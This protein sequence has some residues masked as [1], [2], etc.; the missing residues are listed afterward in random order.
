MQSIDFA[1]AVLLV[2]SLL[3]LAGIFSS[4]IASRLGTPLLLV[5]MA[6]GMLAGEDGPGGIRFSDF[7][8]AYLIGS[9]ALAVI[10]FDGGLRTKLS[11]FRGVLAPSLVL[12]TLGVIITAVITGAIAACLLGIGWVEGFLIGAIV[13]STD[14]AAVFF[15]LGV[16][17]LRLQRR[18]QMTLQNESATNDPMA[19]FLTIGL[20]EVLAVGGGSFTWTSLALFGKQLIL[21]VGLGVAGGFAMVWTLNRIELRPGLHAPFVVTAA[22]AIYSLAAVLE[23]S[24]FLAAYL[25]GLVLGNCQVRAFA[26]ISSFHDAATWMVQIIMFVMLGLLVTPSHLFD[27][28]VPAM[29]IAFALIVVA[30]PVA[31]VLCLLPYRFGKRETAF[32]SWVGLRGAVGIFLASIPML[33]DLPHAG[34]Y[35]NVA[36][37]VVLI[38][39]IVQG[40]TIAPAARWLR[41]ALPQRHLD[42]RRVELDLP[43]QLEYE[44]VG[45]QISAD[46]PLLTTPKLPSWARPL[47]LVRADRI[48]PPPDVRELKSGDYLYVLAPPSRV[49]L[50]DPLFQ[51]RREEMPSVHR[52][53][54][55]PFDGQ[56]RLREIADLYGVDVAPDRLDATLAEYIADTLS[57]DPVEGDRIEEQGYALIVRKMDENRVSQ[58]GVELSEQSSG[59]LRLPAGRTVARVLRPLVKRFRRA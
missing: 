25:A 44:I 42:V 47:L 48:L 30:R 17:G 23:G 50:L 27:Y 4:L 40:W 2:G 8:A 59:P 36:F 12:A 9:F 41:L 13:G 15:L 14:A 5:F 35:F 11:S 45:Y 24:G 22:V 6:I 29:I 52:G 19:A 20:V 37:F 28:L 53:S 54:E 16:G 55:F 10:L 38:S 49:Y 7:R 33:S 1:N 57:E 58:V 51:P 43:G 46:A 21:G 34:L 56:T 39:L 18:A 31:V 26:T 32:I 3:V